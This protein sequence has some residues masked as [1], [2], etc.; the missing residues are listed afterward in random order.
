MT[1]TETAQV[2]EASSPPPDVRAAYLRQ[3]E[4]T[5][6]ADRYVHV[7]DVDVGVGGWDGWIYYSPQAFVDAVESGREPI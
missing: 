3:V 1:R 7:D 4:A 5:Y 6:P 2:R